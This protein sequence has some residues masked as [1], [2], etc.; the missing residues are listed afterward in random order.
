MTTKNT[1]NLDPLTSDNIGST[2]EDD[3]H[4]YAM[5]HWAALQSV[6]EELTRRN[7]IPPRD[8]TACRELRIATA[9]LDSVLDTL[10]RYRDCGSHHV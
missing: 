10:L 2:S 6:V 8:L 4:R 5:H 1:F 7:E 3:L 9:Q